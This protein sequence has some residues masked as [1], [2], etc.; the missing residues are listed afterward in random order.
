MPNREPGVLIL[1]A[2]SGGEPDKESHSRSRWWARRRASS[3]RGPGSRPANFAQSEPWSWSLGVS[4]WPI[5]KAD[6]DLTA[7]Q[8]V[9]AVQGL[10]RYYDKAMNSLSTAQDSEG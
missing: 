4:D 6:Y 9:K 5:G 10:D 3:A 2:V 1:A 7:D 8:A